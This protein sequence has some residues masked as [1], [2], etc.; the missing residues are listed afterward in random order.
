MTMSEEATLADDGFALALW[1]W[2]A[3]IILAPYTDGL[4]VAAMTRRWHES[5]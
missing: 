3:E 1:T 5:R 4:D 2:A